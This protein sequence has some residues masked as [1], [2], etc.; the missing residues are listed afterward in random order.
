MIAPRS[1]LSRAA[2]L[3]GALVALALLTGA[4]PAHAQPMHGQCEPDGTSV[5]GVFGLARL[6]FD[7]NQ[8]A[9]PRGY[10][11]TLEVTPLGTIAGSVQSRAIPDHA[12]CFYV[13]ARGPLLSPVAY[14][15]YADHYVRYRTVWAVQ[16]LHAIAQGRWAE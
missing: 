13:P 7:L 6:E 3:L 11:V 9:N 16:H 4:R 10:D 12:L 2:I 14:A 5:A 8:Y 1:L 15:V